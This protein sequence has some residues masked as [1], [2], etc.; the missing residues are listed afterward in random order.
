MRHYW[1]MIYNSSNDEV[2]LHP[3]SVR[4]EGMSNYIFAASA[5]KWAK[6]NLNGMNGCT[7]IVHS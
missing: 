6:R 7:F 1:K 5:K 4:G 2:H 3:Y